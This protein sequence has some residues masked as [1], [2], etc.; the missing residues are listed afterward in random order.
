MTKSYHNGWLLENWD[1]IKIS[2]VRLA[3]FAAGT[4]G[5]VDVGEHITKAMLDLAILFQVPSSHNLQLEWQAHEEARLVAYATKN[6]L[7]FGWRGQSR[8]DD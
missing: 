3:R 8:T 6:Y 2:R 4:I 5:G 1:G 7:E